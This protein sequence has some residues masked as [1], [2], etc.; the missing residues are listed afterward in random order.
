MRLAAIVLALALLPAPALA[1]DADIEA[2]DDAI[3]AAGTDAGASLYAIST[4]PDALPACR[5]YADR[6][7]V[8]M[9][10]IGLGWTFPESPTIKQLYDL[11]A[12]ALPVYRNDCLLA[13]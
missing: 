12:P 1:S 8:V 4:D 10:L 9:A 13:I 2:I 7:L 6:V 5:D 3:A 11:V